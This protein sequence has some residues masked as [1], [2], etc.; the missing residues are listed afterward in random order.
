MAEEYDDSRAAALAKHLGC[1]LDEI[2]QIGGIYDGQTY[3][4]SPHT[5]RDGVGPAAARKTV[6]LIRKA[7][8]IVLPG[9]QGKEINTGD[10]LRYYHLNIKAKEANKSRE[11]EIKSIE[12][13]LPT[14]GFHHPKLEDRKPTTEDLDQLSPEHHADTRR[15]LGRIAEL[16]QRI[17]ETEEKRA[18]FITYNNMVEL[19]RAECPEL[20]EIG[21]HDLVNGFYFLCPDCE[22]Y[23]KGDE[24]ADHILTYREAF[25]G[26]Q[27]EDRTTPRKTNNGEYLVV[28]DEEADELWDEELEQYIDDCII[29]EVP[30]PYQGY[31]DREGWKEAARVDGRGH[32]LSRYDGTEVE[33]TIY[34]GEEY[35]GSGIPEEIYFIYRT[36]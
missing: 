6:E 13:Q 1:D 20:V 14:L 33:V 26:L 35:E 8:S 12:L 22:E 31:F 9:D 36:N 3:Q 21:L 11:K 16:Q 4:V 29:P 24:L 17:R 34:D 15:K 32:N 10:L 27:I 19:F 30:E 25:D 7:L 28:T 18:G 5:V 23:E 2:E